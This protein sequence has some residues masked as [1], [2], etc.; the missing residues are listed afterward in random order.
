LPFNSSKMSWAFRP[1]LAA[2]ESAWDLFNRQTLAPGKV[3]LLDERRAWL[4]DQYAE[5]GV[6][7]IAKGVDATEGRPAGRP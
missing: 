4:R 6:A 7:L 3:E 1:A 2:A 5:P